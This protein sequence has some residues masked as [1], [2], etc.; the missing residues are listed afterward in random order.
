MTGETTARLRAETAEAH[1]RLEDNLDIF[2]KIASADARRRLVQRFHGLHAGAEAAL[3]PWLTAVDGLAFG[4]RS[5]L[6][7]LRRDLAALGCGD[8]APPACRVAAPAGAAEA[9]GL[10]YVLEGSSLGGRVIGRRLA[11][12]GIDD[13]GLSFLDPYGP[14]VGEQWRAFTAVLERETVGDADREAAVAGAL[15]GFQLALDWLCEAA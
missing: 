8:P 3:A 7:Q 12:D 11:A 5:R 4:D 10:L 13:T 15:R 1:R 14:Q 9:L 6:P 2:G